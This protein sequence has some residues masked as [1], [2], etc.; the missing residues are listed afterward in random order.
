MKPLSPPD[1]LHLQAAEG[2]LELGNHLEADAE[3][4]KITAAK[5]TQPDVLILRW[6]I[7]AKAKKWDACMDIAKAATA[8]APGDA[9][10]W[11]ALAETFY[12]QKKVQEAYD[13]VIVKAP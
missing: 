3:L 4:D 12:F 9:R 2:W 7:Y 6:H 1:S 13:I 10:A 8:I 11:V 5:R